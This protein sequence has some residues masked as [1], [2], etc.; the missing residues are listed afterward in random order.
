MPITK[1]RAKYK[2]WV[3][4]EILA[5]AREIFVREG[6]EKFSMRALAEQI[7]YSTA[8]TYKH[9]K[10]KAEIF[11]RLADES[12]M[13]LMAASEHVKS[14]AA[15]SPV[16]R[17]KRGMLAYVNFGLQNPDHYRIAFLL[18]QLDTA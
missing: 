15:E 5:A 1:K 13:A 4:A 17:L 11:Q 10:S 8:A 12:F 16:A 9:F 18:H 14:I 7:G 2:A 3:Q 6:Y